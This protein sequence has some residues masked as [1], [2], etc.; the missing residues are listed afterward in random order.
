MHI[1]G[2]VHGKIPAYNKLI[3][4]MDE[5]IQLGDMSFEYGQ[6][7]GDLNHRFFHGNHDN[8][9][10][11]HYCPNYLGRYGVYKDFFYVS[12]AFSIDLAFRQLGRINGG[13]KSWWG[14]EELGLEEMINCLKLYKRIK[15]SMVLTHTCP[16]SIEPLIGDP[17]TL[18]RYGYSDYVQKTAELLQMMLDIH[19]P[20]IWL[21]GHFHKS[22]WQNVNGT[23]F[24]CLNELE[25]LKI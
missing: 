7:A 11:I 1:I 8:M 18:E 17:K 2:D 5:S 9:D 22:W 20:S 15:P 6:L 16:L 23:D 12:G 4:K 10:T 3:S 19:R 13:A 21:F 25:P 14:R 24:I